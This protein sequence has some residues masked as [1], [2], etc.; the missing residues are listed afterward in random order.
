MNEFTTIENT[1]KY[2]Q[3]RSTNK[4][5]RSVSFGLFSF[6]LFALT[7]HGIALY[8]MS[9]VVVA[10][11]YYVAKEMNIINNRIALVIEKLEKVHHYSV[12]R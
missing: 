6:G 3:K 4:L 11:F 9:S 10:Y 7:L 1:Q 12:I 8:I 5:Y 2:L